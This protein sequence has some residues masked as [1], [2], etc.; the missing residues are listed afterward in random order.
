MLKMLLA[1]AALAALMLVGCGGG[2]ETTSLTRA[3]FVKQANAICKAQ[4]ERRE[5]IIRKAIAGQDQ[6]KLLPLA[7]REEIVIETVAPYESMAEEMSSLATP[8]GDEPKV[9][10]IIQEME[11]AAKSVRSDPATALGSTSQFQEANNL[12]TRYGLTE[13]AI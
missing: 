4:E 13:C 11:K 12:T 6:T 10:K 3:Q 2:D 8:E 7:Q 5:N 9:E 1:L